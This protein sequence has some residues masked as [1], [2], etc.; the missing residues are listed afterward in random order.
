MQ[1]PFYKT[2]LSAF[3]AG[4]AAADPYDAVLQNMPNFERPPL[5]LAIGKAAIGM[6]TAA[7]DALGGLTDAIIVTNPEN[8][9][10]LEG[11][12][13]FAAAHPVPD[14]VGISAGQAVIAALNAAPLDQPVLCLISGGGSALLPAPKAPM[15]LA[16]KATVND[17]LL[18]SGANIVT[19]NMIRQQLS[20]L[21]GGGLLRHAGPRPMTALILSDVVSDDLRAIASGPTVGPIGTCAQAV[22][23]LQSLN[24]WDGLP[25]S[26]QQVLMQDTPKPELP[27]ATNILIGS[28]DISVSAI[29]ASLPIATHH[30][31]PLEGNVTDAAA[32]VAALPKGTHVFGGE[33]TVTLTGTG[34]GGRN[35]DLA[36][37][38]ALLAEQQGWDGP[39]LYLQGGTDGRDG[40]TDAAGGVVDQHTLK[41][42][43]AAGVDPQAALDNNDSY[44][45]LKAGDVLLIT[46]GTGTNVADI[47]VLIRS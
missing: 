6:A 22:A 44:T 45:A 26:A 25:A 19:M 41:A 34:R 23:E 9:G 39:W 33:T 20:D 35:Q 28:N 7:R 5:V 32:W 18:A 15:T 10:D 24:L 13:I 37:R 46:G 1:H 43:R 8:A 47:G 11:A 16:D 4:V 17:L 42:I 14:H 12:T 40:P 2:A 36:L 38:L 29:V 3:K 27:D 30:T 31:T 21:K